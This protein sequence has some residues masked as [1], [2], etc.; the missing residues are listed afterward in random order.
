M[1]VNG[2]SRECRECMWVDEVFLQGQGCRECTWVDSKCLG[3]SGMPGEYIGW[4]QSTRESQRVQSVGWIPS[5]WGRKGNARGVYGGGCLLFGDATGMP[6]ERMGVGAKCQANVW[7]CM[8][9]ARGYFATSPIHSPGIPLGFHGTLHPPPY[10]LLAFPA[11]HWHN[12]HIPIC[13]PGTLHPP[14]IHSHGIP[15]HSPG[16]H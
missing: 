11:F 6:G 16:F 15:L 12:A 9:C 8:H 2:K 14:P 10:V 5:V 7:G 1:G 3:R 4:M 13:S